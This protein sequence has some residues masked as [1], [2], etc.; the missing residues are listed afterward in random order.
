MKE[1]AVSVTKY[2][3]WCKPVEVEDKKEAAEKVA[4]ILDED[5]KDI[6]A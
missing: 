2:T 6:Y 5:Y 1:L 3:V 4:E